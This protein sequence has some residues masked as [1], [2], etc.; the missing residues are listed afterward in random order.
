MGAAAK[1]IKPN[2]DKWI[3]VSQKCVDAYPSIASA[4]LCGSACTSLLAEPA[5]YAHICWIVAFHDAWW[6]ANF[7]WLS[8]HDQIT[9]EAGFRTHEMAARTLL[10]GRELENLK[11]NWRESPHFEDYNI[12]CTKVTDEMDK[13]CLEVIQKNFFEVSL[14]TY[15]KHFSQ[16]ISPPLLPAM[17][18]AE[19]Q[20]ATMFASWL[21]Q[22]KFAPA[23]VDWCV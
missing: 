2:W 3:S 18:G 10:M 22:G 11:D 1:E 6:N 8:A 5:I 14:L 17:I 16:W 7:V 4:N 13:K 20:T 15:W 19:P 23:P 21:L 12:A 9:G